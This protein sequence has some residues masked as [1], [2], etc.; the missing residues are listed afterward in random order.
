MFAYNGEKKDL[1]AVKIGK[2]IPL[3]SVL[4]VI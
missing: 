1:W 4:T 2:Y 3:L